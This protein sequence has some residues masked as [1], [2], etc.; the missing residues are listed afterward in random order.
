MQFKDYYK[1]LGVSSTATLQEIKIAYR[2]LSKKFHPDIN[3]GDKFFEERFKEIQEA[4]EVLSNSVKRNNYD[5]KWQNERGKNNSNQNSNNEFFRKREEEFEKQKEAYKKW[6]ESLR[7]KE[8]ELKS[9]PNNKKTNK[10]FGAIA[11]VSIFFII[12]AIVFLQRNTATG[13]TGNSSI[14]VSTQTDTTEVAFNTQPNTIPP[15][16]KTNIENKKQPEQLLKENLTNSRFAKIFNGTWKGSA[17]QYNIK[18]RWKIV[19]NCDLETNEFKI[20]YPSLDCSGVWYI[21][22]VSENV[23]SFREHILSGIC[24][25]GGLVKLKIINKRTLEYYVYLPDEIT[26]GAKGIIKKM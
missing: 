11:L 4:Y 26:L 24:D 20:S 10:K 15:F 2:K 12:V 9:K 22:D 18:E 6:E 14:K 13:I 16:V 25:E 5:F 3:D 7:K 8:E 19:L 21:E 17:F 23:I 1:T